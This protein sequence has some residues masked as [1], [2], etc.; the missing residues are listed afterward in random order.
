MHRIAIRIFSH[1]GTTESTSRIVRRQ[2]GDSGYHPFSGPVARPAVQR[3]G[4]VQQAGGCY[5]TMWAFRGGARHGAI[6]A[7]TAGPPAAR[8]AKPRRRTPAPRGLPYEDTARARHH[9]PATVS[10]AAHT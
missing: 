7:R 4:T 1:A 5:T 3:H 8:R 10:R 2:R 6:F 9:P